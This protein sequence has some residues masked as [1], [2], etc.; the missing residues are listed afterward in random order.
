[1]NKYKNILAFLSIIFLVSACVTVIDENDFKSFS[2]TGSFTYIGSHLDYLYFEFN[3]PKISKRN[4]V[5]IHRDVFFDLN[6]LEGFQE[7]PLG[8]PSDPV[9][10]FQIFPHDHEIF[11]ELFNIGT[12]Q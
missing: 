8:S 1:M 9:S 7:H 5:K 6:P 3:K 11:N 12:Q 4:R 2:S 10:V